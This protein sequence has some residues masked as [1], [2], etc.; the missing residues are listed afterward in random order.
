MAC[1]GSALLYFAWQTCSATYLGV[2]SAF[3]LGRGKPRKIFIELPVRR[4]FRVRADLQ[5]A[6]RHHIRQP[7]YLKIVYRLHTY[8]LGKK[9]ISCS[10][11]LQCIIRH[12]YQFLLASSFLQVYSLVCVTVH[13][14]DPP[15]YPQQSGTGEKIFSTSAVATFMRGT[16]N[17]KVCV[18][19]SWLGKTLKVNRYLCDHIQHKWFL[20]YILR[21]PDKLVIW[22]QRQRTL[23]FVT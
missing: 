13:E 11:S 7:L 17:L 18:Q 2:N 21:L 23:I 9:Q 20:V 16:R 14:M 1:G 8:A 19:G 3:A 5:P 15:G 12:T 4:M 6:V 10:S 22:Q